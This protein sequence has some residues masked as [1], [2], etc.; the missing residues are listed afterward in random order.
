MKFEL[1]RVIFGWINHF[2]FI[3]WLFSAQSVDFKENPQKLQLH[4]PVFGTHTEVIDL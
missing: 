4:I 3:R 2:C 1:L